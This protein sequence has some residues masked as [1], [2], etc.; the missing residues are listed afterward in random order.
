MTRLLARRLA[1]LSLPCPGF[2][3]LRWE[4]TWRALEKQPRAALSS[5][6]ACFDF[7]GMA[8]D[9]AL[10]LTYSALHVPGEAQKIDRVVQAFAN[11][12]LS[13]CLGPLLMR[14]QHM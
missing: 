2:Q 9:D 5:F 3:R 11:A 1:A 4:T 8:L 10:R 12:F 13:K 6:M 14:P 7:S